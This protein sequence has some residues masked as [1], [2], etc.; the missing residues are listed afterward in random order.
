[1]AEF[2][3]LDLFH[4]LRKAGMSLTLE[5]YDLLKQ[6][7][8]Q[9]YGLK[10]WDDLRRLCRLLWVKPCLNYD[11]ERFE[12][13]FD[14][15]VQS[16]HQQW[17]AELESPAPST[18]HQKTDDVPGLPIVP[19]R[20]MPSSSPVAEGQAPVAVRT[21]PPQYDLTPKPEFR[22]M[23]TQMPVSLETIRGSWRTLRQFV[24][25]GQDEELD[26]EGTIARINRD[27]FFSEVVMRPRQVQR[28]ELLVLVDENEAMVPFD[29]A[30]QPLITAVEEHRI[31]PAQLYRFTVF[32]D[33]FL[34]EWQ[35][36]TQ[37]VPLNSLLSRLHRS[38][39]V[40]W[41]V[42]DAGAAIG[43][44]NPE[45]LNGVMEFLSRLL[46]CIR[47]LLWINP[48]PEK[49]WKSTTA[50][51]IAQVL[52]GRMIALDPV[53]LQY[54]AGKPVSAPI[55]NRWSLPLEVKPSMN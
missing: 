32:P 35:Y 25:E 52:D 2:P 36:P 37:A 1:M 39:T 51:A 33:E 34:Y 13:A 44:Y 48:L 12:R 6:A 27:G 24:C 45:R 11:G 7:L 54:A 16:L 38:R 26:L 15:Y 55:L 50:E 17:Q 19:P 3:F 9:G 53:Y 29:P 8:D 21:S 22:L 49:R 42:S 43:T 47:E 31:S 30:I 40:V 18:Q 4:H 10:G 23:P 46:P 41:I 14:R 20:Q 5:Q 28:A